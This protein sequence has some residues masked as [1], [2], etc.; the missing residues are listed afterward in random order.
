MSF[1]SKYERGKARLLSKELCEANKILFNKFFDYEERKLKRMNGLRELDDRCYKTLVGYVQKFKNVNVWFKGKAWESLTREEIKSVLDKLEDGKIQRQDGSILM[2][3]ASYYNKIFKS[4]PFE[5]AGK[6]GFV[7]EIMREEFF[8]MNEKE[9]VRFIEGE[10][11]LKLADKIIQLEHKALLW[12]L[13]DLGENINSVLELT[14]KDFSRRVNPDTK[15]PEYLVNLRKDILKRSRKARGEPTLYKETAD[16]LDQL[17]K[18]GKAVKKT[19][20]DKRTGRISTTTAGYAP[21]ELEDKVFDFGY[22]SVV[23]FFDRAVALSGAKVLPSGDKPSLK[24]LRSGMACHLL[25]V[26]WSSDEVNARLGH[27]VASK[28]IGKYLNYLA[29]DRG[30]PKQKIYNN[31]LVKINEELEEMKMREKLYQKREERLTTEVDELKQRIGEQSIR[32]DEIMFAFFHRKDL[33]E[34]QK[35]AIGSVGLGIALSEIKRKT[36]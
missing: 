18:R 26:G 6:S 35:M 28:E 20:N 16:Y 7:K 31:T 9:D 30:K 29:I 2:D 36:E 3:K 12:L 14:Y 22:R 15:E 4:V 25:K 27:A 19:L 34:I 23:K 33:N 11:F 24:D 13:W 21:F 32:L 17:F 1:K 10:S 8:T 5:M